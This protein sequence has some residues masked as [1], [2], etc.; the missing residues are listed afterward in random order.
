MF[1]DSCCCSC[2]P[3]FHGSFPQPLLVFSFIHY[4]QIV[5]AAIKVA[6]SV[7][8]CASE[9]LKLFAAMDGCN[10]DVR[11]IIFSGQFQH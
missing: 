4:W 6:S 5:F 1:D 11:I 7:M 3:P 10:S 9:F 2:F 8:D